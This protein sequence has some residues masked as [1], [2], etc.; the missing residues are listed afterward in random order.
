MTGTTTPS[1]LANCFAGYVA[2]GVAKASLKTAVDAFLANP[3]A[4]EALAAMVAARDRVDAVERHEKAVSRA[5]H[6]RSLRQQ[7]ALDNETEETRLARVRERVARIRMHETAGEVRR[8]QDLVGEA[9]RALIHARSALAASVAIRDPPGVSRD[10]VRLDRQREAFDLAAE[11]WVMAEATA[12]DAEAA[13]RATVLELTQRDGA[14]P[15]E[16][17]VDGVL[18]EAMSG[19]LPSTEAMSVPLQPTPKETP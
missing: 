7:A 12:K 2:A 15:G 17:M 11:T 9:V 13:W 19:P 18:D 14:T 8:T 6:I 16:K 10:M 1:P 3:T 4:P 5:A